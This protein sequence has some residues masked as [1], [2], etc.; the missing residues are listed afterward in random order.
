MKP[1]IQVSTNEF[2]SIKAK[3]EQQ[4]GAQ[5]PTIVCISLSFVC[6]YISF[7][8]YQDK[9]K[10]W[11]PRHMQRTIDWSYVCMFVTFYRIF[12]PYFLLDLLS[13][14]Y[15]FKC[16]VSSILIVVLTT[17]SYSFA[18]VGRK[19]EKEKKQ[20]NFSSFA[21]QKRKEEKNFCYI[22]KSV[23]QILLQNYLH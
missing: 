8:I 18:I 9:I 15:S 19:Q 4:A 11:V 13:V 22:Q 16:I 10:T 21:Q 5:Q 1:Y 20:Q 14:L 6:A 3:T 12:S 23:C 17:C 2:Q 7:I